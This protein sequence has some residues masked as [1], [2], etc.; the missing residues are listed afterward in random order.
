MHIPRLDEL[1]VRVPVLVIL[2]GS[3]RPR[4]RVRGFASA[5]ENRVGSWKGLGL[6]ERDGE[7]DICLRL[8]PVCA[9]SR[10]PEFILKFFYRERLV[11]FKFFCRK[12]TPFFYSP[13]HETTARCADTFFFLGRRKKKD[14]LMHICR[15]ACPLNEADLR[16][17]A[18]THVRPL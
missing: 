16:N 10:A 7:R 18:D 13:P 1:L 11:L 2:D 17:A 12:S 14:R 15:V 8:C 9:A 3:E 6:G 4:P 5:I